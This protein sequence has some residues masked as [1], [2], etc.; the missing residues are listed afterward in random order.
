MDTV[1]IKGSNLPGLRQILDRG[2]S[3]QSRQLGTFLE[4]K[5][6]SYSNPRPIFRTTFLN[7]QF[8]IG[9]DMDDNIFVYVKTSDSTE[10]T[11]YSVVD[12]DLG[13]GR[14]LEG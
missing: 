1:E 3:L 5:L 8:R 4:D 6:S 13:V 2:L 12:A 7:E 11:N 14:L 9:R 10:P